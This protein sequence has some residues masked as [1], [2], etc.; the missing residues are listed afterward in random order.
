[1][2]FSPEADALIAWP[3]GQAHPNLSGFS[4]SDGQVTF[5]IA[6]AGCLDTGRLPDAPY[7]AR[8]V[9]DGIVVVELQV[10]TAP[11]VVNSEGLLP[12]ELGSSIC[13]NG[14]STVG[15]SDAVFHINAIKNGLVEP[16][17]KLTGD[18]ADPVDLDDAVLLTPY[19]KAGGSFTCDAAAAPRLRR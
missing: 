16:C 2:R 11:D 9:A 12:S 1:M 5:H 13:E 4:D 19:I 15:L 3:V 18:P 8:I 6:G 10:V 17:S 14:I 7:L